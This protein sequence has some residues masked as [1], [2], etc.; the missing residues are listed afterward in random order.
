MQSKHHVQ[1]IKTTVIGGVLFLVP[2]AFLLFLLGKA[3][4]FMMVIATPMAK[5]I[6]ID[7]IG[8]IALANLIALLALVLVCFVA[9][10]AAR[11]ALAG[12]VIRQLEEKV[13]V[14]FP[15]YALVKGIKTGVEKSEDGQMKPVVVDL[16]FCQRTGFR[17]Q[18][19]ADGRCVVYL[20]GSPNTWSGI[21]LIAAAD[22]V[23]YLDVPWKDMIELPEAYGF[24]TA[25]VLAAGRSKSPRAADD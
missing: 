25:E 22:Q 20:P 17:T 24:G 10:L 8:G 15:G 16:G 12:G 23:E 2:V 6:P 21:T 9:G 7:T 18:Q 14:K 11:T 5:W 13:L 19:L 4:N 1:F 3:F